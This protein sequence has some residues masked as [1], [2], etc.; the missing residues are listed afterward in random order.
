MMQFAIEPGLPGPVSDLGAAL[1][2]PFDLVQ[3]ALAF[4]VDDRRAWVGAQ[5]PV[6]LCVILSEAPALEERQR[7]R[8]CPRGAPATKGLPSRSR[9]EE[10]RVGKECRSRR[11]P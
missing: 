1:S 4:L 2:Q 3:R 9:S 7:R 8:A 11:A 5:D 6:A 10:R